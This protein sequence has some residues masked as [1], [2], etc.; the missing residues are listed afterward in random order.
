MTYNLV[1]ICKTSEVFLVLRLLNTLFGRKKTHHTCVVLWLWGRMSALESKGHEYY[2][3][4]LST[5]G[6]FHWPI[7]LVHVLVYSQEAESR[8]NMCRI[9][10]ISI[11][12]MN[13]FLNPFP[14]KP[15]FSCGC[16]TCLLKTQWGKEKLLVTGNFFFS[17]SVFFSFEKLSPVLIK[18]ET[19]V[20]KLLEFG[21]V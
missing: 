1:L 9:K 12:C 11:I 15:C 6:A 3:R 20:C 16:C 17:C 4:D 19:V 5:F 13:M 14:N 10:K 18:F 2:S 21:R 7:Y 8:K